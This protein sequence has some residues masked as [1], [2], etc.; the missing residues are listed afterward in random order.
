MEE[1]EVLRAIAKISRKDVAAVQPHLSLGSLGLGA[2]FGL[3]ALRTLLESTSGAK[4]PPLSTNTTVSALLSA[5]SESNQL[6]AP[7]APP[8]S[9]G[10]MAAPVNLDEVAPVRLPDLTSA[11]SLAGLG[12][13]IDMQEID[14]LPVARDYRVDPFYTANFHPAEI[15][16][17]MLRPDPRA[18]LCGIFCAKE[19]AKKTHPAL[20]DLRLLEFVVSHDASGR[21]RL[22]LADD[23]AASRPFHFVI[24]I[25][26]TNHFAAATCLS[27]EASVERR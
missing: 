5:L 6:P 16:T 18:H 19:A 21:P 15:A 23:I 9:N 20:L 10:A 7:S 22:A 8:L 2:S 3:T 17:A 1:K 24:S 12:L 13:G 11:P 25:S 4:L 26:H 14:S 27:T